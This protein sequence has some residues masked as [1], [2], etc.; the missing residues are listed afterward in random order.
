MA[1]SLALHLSGA[2]AAQLLAASAGSAQ[3]G[4]TLYAPCMA[5]HALTENRIGPRH[6]GVVGRR[7]GSLRDF[8]Y[9]PAMRGA[10]IVWTEKTLDAFLADPQ[11][12]LPGTA[13]IFSGVPARSDRADLIAWLATARPGSPLCR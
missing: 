2:G 4:E 7:A 12:F 6:C 10:K 5:C 9:S 1:L 8:D 3:R 11:K 13:M